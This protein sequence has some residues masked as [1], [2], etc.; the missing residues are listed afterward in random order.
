[1]D[2]R[3][4]SVRELSPLVGPRE[5]GKDFAERGVV[6]NTPHHHK[7]VIRHARSLITLCMSAVARGH[8][9]LE[10]SFTIAYLENTQ[11]TEC[12]ALLFS[13]NIAHT[14]Y[15]QLMYS[16]LPS[17]HRLLTSLQLVPGLLDRLLVAVCG[18]TSLYPG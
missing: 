18:L 2:E 10:T 14:H 1:M 17:P 6:N 12:S 3:Y 8:G 4:S 9:L 5:G 13:S 15:V 16:S 7:L 11:M